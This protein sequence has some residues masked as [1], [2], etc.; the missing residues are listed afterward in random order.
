M[1]RILVQTNDYRTV[2]DERHVRLA[3]I[4]ECLCLL[5]RLEQAVK[6]AERPP[7]RSSRRLTHMAMN[8]DMSHAGRPAQRE[9]WPAAIGPGTS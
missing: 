6:E 4:N 3:D 9:S 1:A 8:G 2:L 5:D 7:T